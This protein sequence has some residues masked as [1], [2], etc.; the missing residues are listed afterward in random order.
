M[1]ISMSSWQLGQ[2][3]AQIS[4][5]IDPELLTGGMLEL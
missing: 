4:T 1:A 3:I 5:K 2:R